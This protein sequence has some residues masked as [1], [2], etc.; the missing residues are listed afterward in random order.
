[1]PK[2]KK[3][4]RKPSLYKMTELQL[5][6]TRFCD[7]SVTWQKTPIERLVKKIFHELKAKKILHKPHIWL[8][9]EWFSPDHHPGIAV[10]FYLAHPRLKELEKK[11][12]YEI[13]GGAL[14]DALKILRHEAGH[15]ICTAYRLHYKPKWRKVFGSPT[16]PYPKAYKPEPISKKHVLHLGWWY[17][18]AHPDEDFAE[19]FAVWLSTPKTIWKERY[20]TWPALKKLECVDELM[21]EIANKKPL[22]QSRRTIEPLSQNTD[23]LGEHYKLRR[24]IYSH[25]L[26]DLYDRDLFRLFPRHTKNK[27]GKKASQFLRENRNLIR[28]T[29]AKWTREH[30]YPIDQVLNAMIQ[31]CRD[32][33][34]YLPAQHTETKLD[35]IVMMTVH[36]MGLLYKS[37]RWILL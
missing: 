16:K 3:T 35:T 15:A 9:T 21:Q 13:E 25:E 10:P 30:E 4:G 18:Q 20:Q 34:L 5:L 37:R 24:K 14:K 28:Q 19:T 26:P 6:Q 1:M 12:M 8:S 2:P 27:R 11:M 32:L 31:R 33:N 22:V 36:I 17:A 7:L 23:T 29:I